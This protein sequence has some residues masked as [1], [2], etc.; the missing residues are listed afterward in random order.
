M[1]Q[2]WSCWR[3]LWAGYGGCLSIK[4]QRCQRNRAPSQ[5]NSIGCLHLGSLNWLRRVAGYPTG[6]FI[7]SDRMVFPTALPCKMPSGFV[8]V[9]ACRLEKRR[10]QIAESGC[11]S[12]ACKCL[13]KTQPPVSTDAGAFGIGLVWDKKQIMADHDQPGVVGE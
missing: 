1:Q 11:D 8:I 4:L 7:F 5:V 9:I 12:R 2:D 10:L 3:N 13:N 6:T